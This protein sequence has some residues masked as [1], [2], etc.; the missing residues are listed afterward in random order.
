MAYQLLPP[1]S[2]DEYESL[3][4][5]IAK[6]GVLVPI[7]MDENGNVLDGHHRIEICNEL[8]LNDWPVVTK[9]FGSEE[10]KQAYI[11]MVNLARRQLSRDQLREIREEQ[12]QL[13]LLLKQ[14][15]DKSQEEIAGLMGVSQP[16]ISI[17][18]C[19]E[20]I[21]NINT[22]NANIDLRLSIM[23]EQKDDIFERAQHGDT[24]AKIAADY[25]VSQGRI[26][27]VVKE[28]KKKQKKKAKEKAKAA[29]PKPNIVVPIIMIG[30]AG[31]LDLDDALIDVII[32]SPP[33]N[34]GSEHWPMGGQGR[35]PRKNGIGYEDSKP[36]NEYQ[37]EQ[38]KWLIEWYRVAKSGASLFYNHK[39]R[40]KEGEMIHPLDWLRSP[41]NPWILRQEIIWDR[42]STHN[43][44]PSLFWPQDERIYWMTKEK[45]VVPEDGIGLPSVWRF[46]G[47]EPD[48]WHPAPFPE[49]LPRRCL[50]AIGRPGII[51]LDP[52]GGRMTTCKVASEMS[53]KSIG[54]DINPVYVERAKKE[55]G[56]TNESET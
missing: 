54:I 44:C 35:Q 40:Q 55:N 33:Y 31:S 10:E 19:Q 47:P 15:Q 53:Y 23:Q 4:A 26:S 24:Q 52:C 27:Q 51:V 3:K 41:D 20:N 12:K 17:W 25:G 16:T 50:K 9:T 7:E 6:H 38:V 32:T 45:P 46:H 14:Q 1:L 13:A 36:E 11:Y 2:Q 21:S 37:E 30:D 18:L 56:W 39:V 22:N 34:L 42:E 48:T 29:Q 5:S 8:S 43:H 28:E 49:E